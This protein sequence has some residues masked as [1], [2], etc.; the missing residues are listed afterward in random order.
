MATVD[1]FHRFIADHWHPAE[2]ATWW[3]QLAYLVA[4]ILVGVALASAFTFVV[5]RLMAGF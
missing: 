2:H 1:R 3:E 5:P 4:A